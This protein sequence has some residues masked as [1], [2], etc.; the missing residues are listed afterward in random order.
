M[1]RQ[2]ELDNQVAAELAGSED[3][4]LRTLEAHLDCDIFLRGNMLTLE[5]DADA[6]DNAA[7]VIRELAELIAQGHEIAPGTI[8]TP[9]LQDI[10][11][12]MRE[13][14]AN[15]HM[16]KRLGR[17]SEIAGMM[18]YLFDPTDGAFQT[19]LLFPVD[20]GWSVNGLN[21]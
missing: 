10:T 21:Y 7:G 9:I 4:V 8:D 6:V 19:G 16:I 2:V 20:G 1:R 12:E 5:G 17:P 15:S 11:D 14:N 18:A 13:Q 3:S